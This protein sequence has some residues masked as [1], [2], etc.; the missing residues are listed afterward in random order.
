MQDKLKSAPETNGTTMDFE[1]LLDEKSRSLYSADH[2]YRESTSVSE[3]SSSNDITR[4]QTAA[5]WEDV[6]KT[7]RM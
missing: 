7:I 4:P 2:S 5:M 1:F 3:S 6:L